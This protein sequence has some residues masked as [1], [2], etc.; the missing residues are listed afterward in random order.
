M[1]WLCATSSEYKIGTDTES[2]GLEGVL[3]E[4]KVGSFGLVLGA[5]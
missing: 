3:G 5:V 1:N 4:G 2:P